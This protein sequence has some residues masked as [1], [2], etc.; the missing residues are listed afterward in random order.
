ARAHCDGDRALAPPSPPRV[1][2]PRE[3][4]VRARA[5]E[6]I[7]QWWLG[8]GITPP[9]R[10]ISP[11]CD[12]I[13]RRLGCAAQLLQSATRGNRLMATA[14]PFHLAATPAQ[15]SRRT[16]EWGATVAVFVT[17]FQPLSGML[18]PQTDGGSAGGTS[19]LNRL[20]LA[21]AYA[22]ILYVTARDRAF[23]PRGQR[24]DHWMALLIGLA[25]VSV[26]WS[27]LPGRS[28]SRGI[29][30]IVTTWFGA[31]LGRRYTLEEQILLLAHALSVIAI[32]SV[33]VAIASPDVGIMSGEF[34][35]AW[36]GVF[37]HKN[38]LGR[39]A[40]LGCVVSLVVASMRDH[41]RLG[42]GGFAVWF[43]LLVLST[44]SSALIGLIAVAAL[45]PLYRSLRK[46]G[47]VLAIYAVAAILVPT[48]IGIWTY[49]HLDAVLDLLGK[50]LTLSG[51]TSLWF[52]VSSF[53]AE[54]PL[55]GYGFNAFWQGMNG[56]SGIISL[57]LHWEVPHAH[58]GILELA[59]DTGL[60][61]VLL[62][63]G[64]FIGT[65]RQAIRVQ[66]QGTTATALW[67][68]L[69]LTFILITNLT[70]SSLLRT[71]SS[72]WVLYLMLAFG[73]VAPALNAEHRGE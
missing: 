72:Y 60:L 3:W 53:I 64:S 61:G 25:V 70:E 71:N 55:L 22:F 7:A 68:L 47:I 15:T 49:T 14:Q 27:T 52:A 9:R 57:A 34:E 67:P 66:T 41:R 54:R 48:V 13:G 23:I 31:Y 63:V 2:P 43:S 5:R 46:R 4:R 44:S 6:C 35:G 32:M 19:V 20:L 18:D 30:L 21:G 29:Q 26:L 28:L 33:L 62:F 8:C 42:L 69:G 17:F 59:L 50:N 36:R 40:F 12:A 38:A 24:R 45:V 58:N 10:T 37:G 73:T 51:R 11:S 39:A 56:D 16:L 1:A 65:L